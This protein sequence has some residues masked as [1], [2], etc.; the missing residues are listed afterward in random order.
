MNPRKF[1]PAIAAFA[2]IVSTAF[3]QDLNWAQLAQRPDLWPAQ[4]TLLVPMKF[5]DGASVPAGQKVQ[6][7]GVKATE[8]DYTTLDGKINFAADP[9][10]TDLLKVAKEALAKLTPKQ[11]ALT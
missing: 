11:R 8:A 9:D 7:V 3:A 4:C 2:V 5:G 10:E 6:V 1:L